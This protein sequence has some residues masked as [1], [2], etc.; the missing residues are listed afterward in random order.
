[1]RW[2]LVAEL[3]QTRGGEEVQHGIYSPLLAPHILARRLKSG[4]A[5]ITELGLEHVVPVV[6]SSAHGIPSFSVWR[7]MSPG[8]PAG[9]EMPQ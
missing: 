8:S 5:C 9:A 4:W 3:Q 7:A 6:A 2:Q 1:M